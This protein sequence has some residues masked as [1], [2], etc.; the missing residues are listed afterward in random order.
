MMECGSAGEEL[1]G[2]VL[3][4]RS[5]LLFVEHC[6][7]VMSVIYLQKR[8]SV[9]LVKLFDLRIVAAFNQNGLARN[10]FINTINNF[11][12]RIKHFLSRKF[13]PYVA[14]VSLFD[15]FS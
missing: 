1:S 10:Q 15:I 11:E 9:V 5:V 14:L 3:Y 6:I 4:L 7:L 12:N 13:G 8:E 2:G